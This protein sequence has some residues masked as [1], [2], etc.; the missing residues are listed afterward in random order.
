MCTMKSYLSVKSS[1]CFNVIAAISVIKVILFTSMSSSRWMR[2]WVVSK[3][4]LTCHLPAK[5]C[6]IRCEEKRINS[7][8][9]KSLVM[10]CSCLIWRVSLPRGWGRIF[11]TYKVLVLPAKEIS[12]ISSSCILLFS[13]GSGALLL[14]F[15]FDLVVKYKSISYE[16]PY[17]GKLRLWLLK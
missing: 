2:F 17:I 1:S 4:F 14:F 13:A 5:F 6:F 9:A 11:F 12:Y 16:R 3:R 8:L 10:C 15:S 7:P